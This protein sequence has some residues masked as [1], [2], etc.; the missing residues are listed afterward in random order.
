M[1]PPWTIGER[2]EHVAIDIHDLDAF[3]PR[4]AF[5][6]ERLMESSQLLEL[7]SFLDSSRHHGHHVEV[8]LAGV[9]PTSCKRAEQVQPEQI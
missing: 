6:N 2:S 9:E 3:D 1:Q 5:G 7:L 8:A 4:R